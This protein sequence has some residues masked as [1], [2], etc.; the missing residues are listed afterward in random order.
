MNY[1][2]ELTWEEF[3]KAR[4]ARKCIVSVDGKIICNKNHN[5]PDEGLWE[6]YRQECVQAYA[7]KYPVSE[8]VIR[9][10]NEIV[11]AMTQEAAPAP[12]VN[13]EPENFDDLSFDK[14]PEPENF[15]DLSF[16]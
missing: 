13:S 7:R 1:A 8:E 10:N 12:V 9:S 2:W 3:L 6:L 11:I 16:V 5:V 15:D 4:A 14:P